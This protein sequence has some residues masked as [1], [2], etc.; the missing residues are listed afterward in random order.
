LR[1]ITNPRTTLYLV[2]RLHSASQE[3]EQSAVL[4]TSELNY[5]EL[6]I[7]SLCL[8]NVFEHICLSTHI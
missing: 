5:K 6:R 1:E 7:K 3:T 8:E 2:T 4:V